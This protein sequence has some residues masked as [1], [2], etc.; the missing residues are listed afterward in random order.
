MTRDV[1][2][3]ISLFA[4]EPIEVNRIALNEDQIQMYQPPPNPA[5]LTDSRASAYI[6]RYGGESWELDALDPKTMSAL[7]ERIVLEY[8][9]E[10][11]W[12]TMMERRDDARAT[13]RAIS[14]R[15]DDVQGF[16]G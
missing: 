6:D 13:L 14:D 7:I 11:A 5:K 3:R 9:H 15:F 4:E 16:L 12:E 8:R 10:D 2:D 1:D